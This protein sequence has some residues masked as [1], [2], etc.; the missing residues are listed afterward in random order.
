MGCGH[1]GPPH[2][3]NGRMMALP[4][5]IPPSHLVTCPSWASNSPPRCTSQ[6]NLHMGPESAVW[7]YFFSIV[8][9]GVEWQAGWPS[10]PG[11]WLAK[12]SAL[13]WEGEIDQVQE[14]Q[15]RWLL[16]HSD[17]W[18]KQGIA[19]GCKCHLQKP[20]CLC[21]KQK[22]TFCKNIYKIKTYW[23]VCFLGAMEGDKRRSI[24][25]EGSMPIPDPLVK[26]LWG[27]APRD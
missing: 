22:S 18:E 9:G 20:K 13:Q 24:Y 11:G 25:I 5:G 17:E 21:A 2:T 27:Q 23:T 16:K 7:G 4:S 12:R 3:A 8:C 1:V 6:R 26:S 14:W 15:Q 19:W 10:T